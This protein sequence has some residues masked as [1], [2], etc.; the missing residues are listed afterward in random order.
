MAELRLAI[1]G[2]AEGILVRDDFPII[3]VYFYVIGGI[4]R[5]NVG[6]F[7]QQLVGADGRERSNLRDIHPLREIRIRGAAPEAK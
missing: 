3:P 7:Y 4:V 5:E 6:G 2:E 1:L